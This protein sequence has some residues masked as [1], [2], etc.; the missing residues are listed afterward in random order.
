M[1]T[2]HRAWPFI[3]ACAALLEAASACFGDDLTAVVHSSTGVPPDSRY[4]LIQSPLIA[5]LMLRV[6][7]FNGEVDHFVLDTQGNGYFWVPVKMEKSALKDFH[8]YADN[9]V[10]FQVFTSGLIVEDTFLIDVDTGKTWILVK[11]QKDQQWW[12]NVH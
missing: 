10:H 8:V 12:E 1:S 3:L 4:E 9:R 2:L 7:R 6:D 5:R 11:D